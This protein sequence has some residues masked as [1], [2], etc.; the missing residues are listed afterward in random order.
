MNADERLERLEKQ[1]ARMASAI[2]DENCIGVEDESEVCRSVAE[3]LDPPAPKPSAFEKCIGEVEGME[4]FQDYRAYAAFI[5][6]VARAHGEKLGLAKAIADAAWWLRDQKKATLA[7]NL[8]LA[9]KQQ[10]P[11]E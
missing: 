10:E 9:L 3:I 4:K 8:V 1:V 6:D 11:G 5:W 7:D 2:A